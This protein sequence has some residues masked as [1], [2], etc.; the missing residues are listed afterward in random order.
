MQLTPLCSH[1]GLPD[2]PQRRLLAASPA[3]A[4]ALDAA[5]LT[6]WV[7]LTEPGLLICMQSHGQAAVLAA[8]MLG[9][10]LVKAWLSR[11]CLQATGRLLHPA[12]FCH[13]CSRQS[14]YLDVSCCNCWQLARLPASD[15]Q[16]DS[17][18]LKIPLQPAGHHLAQL[19]V[20]ARVGKL[21]LLAA[22]LGCLGP[23]LTV[24]ASLSYK[25]PFAASNDQQDAA[26]RVRQALAAT[27]RLDASAR[28]G[29]LQGQ[30]SLWV[31]NC[32]CVSFPATQGNHT[33]MAATSR[34]THHQGGMLGKACGGHLLW[35]VLSSSHLQHLL[36][37]CAHCCCRKRHHCIRAAV[38]SPPDGGSL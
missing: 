19:P 12:G 23:A 3:Q 24:A 28:H 9:R 5:R 18:S 10:L 17:V 20:D 7:A 1:R 32:C 37:R 38:R 31:W 21:L 2:T 33:L 11:Y 26:A 36:V 8:E 13:C 15:G 25:S 22:S 4:G 6:A 35:T 16:P 29:C 14:A 27:G 30:S 34:H